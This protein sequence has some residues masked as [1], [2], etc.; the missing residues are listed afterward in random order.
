MSAVA[1]EQG[2]AV[3]DLSREGFPGWVRWVA[4][5]TPL[6]AGA[7]GF[8]SSSF[9]LAVV[10]VLGC[11]A[12]VVGWTDA[13]LRRIPNVMC[14]SP[15]CMPTPAD[16]AAS[17]SESL[18]LADRTDFYRAWQMVNAAHEYS[19]TVRARAFSVWVALFGCVTSDGTVTRNSTEVAEEFSV[20]RM[21][22]KQYRALLEEVGL[23]EQARVAR[24]T[25]RPTVVR[26]RPPLR[27]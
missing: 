25:Q 1:T 17:S 6:L 14:G 21:S 4:F 23:I 9:F 27:K 13:R 19:P 16:A 8:A 20:S 2:V 5:A 12:G 18:S 7:V 26:V 10:A 22:W 24:G 11:S 3:D 15:V